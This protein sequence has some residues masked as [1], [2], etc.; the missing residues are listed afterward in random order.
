VLIDADELDPPK[1]EEPEPR[2]TDELRKD[3]DR[4]ER[5]QIAEHLPPDDEQHKALISSIRGLDANQREELQT[6]IDEHAVWSTAYI[7]E[8]PDS[9]FL[10]IESGGKKDDEGKTTPR[11][12][13][14]FPVRDATGAVDMAHVRNALSRIPQ[15]SLPQSVKDQATRKAESLMKGSKSTEVEDGTHEEPEKVKSRPQDPLRQRSLETVLEIS[16]HGLSNRK[17]SPEKAA[18]KMLDEAELKRRS[19]NLELEILS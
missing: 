15:S 11:S 17:P 19:R 4:E 6:L 18:P 2:T 16:S 12:L 5:Q 1:E 8:L 3:A 7:N 9:A 13:R 10:H 14:H